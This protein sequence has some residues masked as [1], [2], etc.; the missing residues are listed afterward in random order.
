MRMKKRPQTSNP[1]YPPSPGPRIP[2]RILEPYPDFSNP[3]PEQCN[4]VRDDLL[5]A[6]GFPTQFA[7]HRRKRAMRKNQTRTIRSSDDERGECENK[8]NDTVLDGVV[9]LLLSQN[10][11][12]TNS[13]RAFLSL[14]STFP[15][16]ENVSSLIILTINPNLIRQT[17]VFVILL[18]CWG[19]KTRFWR[20]PYAV[21]D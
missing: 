6:D 11:T 17:S 18:R 2:V 5:A 8:R 10:T 14:K 20:V 13:A 12:E 21:G 7:D 19:R 3:T 15:D 4:A 16:W 1:F 9:N